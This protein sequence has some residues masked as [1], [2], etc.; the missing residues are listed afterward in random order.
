MDGLSVALVG[1]GGLYYISKDNRDKEQFKN[2]EFSQNQGSAYPIHNETID[3]D[4]DEY[5]NKTNATQTTDKFYQNIEN[6]SELFQTTSIESLNGKKASDA[7]TQPLGMPVFLK[8]IFVASTLLVWP[9][10]IL[11]ILLFF[12]TTTKPDV[13][14]SIL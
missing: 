5:I 4:D 7:T 8:A 3:K 1:L 6:N 13:F 2:R 10:E 11:M 12:A 14:L 9:P